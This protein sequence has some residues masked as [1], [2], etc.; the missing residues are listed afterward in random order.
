MPDVFTNSNSFKIVSFHGSDINHF[1]PCDREYW[2][3]VI[4]D[5][6]ARSAKTQRLLRPITTFDKLFGIAQHQ[7]VYIALVGSQR[8]PVGLGKVGKKRIFHLSK[9]NNNIEHLTCECLLDFYI[10][11]DYQRR[12]YG[13][14]V[15]DAIIETEPNVEAVHDL[16][17][18]RPSEAC[19]AFFE[20]HY[21][22]KPIRV[23][24]DGS[25]CVFSDKALSTSPYQSF[26]E[27]VAESNATSTYYDKN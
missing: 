4:N 21:S 5:L 12:G 14:I 2:S 9:D 18:D 13:K 24:I 11:E 7:R 26:H 20:K 23:G 25:F 3:K 19:L 8:K 17:I 15:M 10:I 6:G 27:Y 22:L 1:T 16:G